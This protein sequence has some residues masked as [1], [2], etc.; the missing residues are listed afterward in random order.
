MSDITAIE[1]IDGWSVVRDPGTADIVVN[2]EEQEI[3][4][5]PGL[6]I[7]GVKFAEDGS[8][9]SVTVQLSSNTIDTIFAGEAVGFPRRMDIKEFRAFGFLQ[10]VNRQ[11]FHPLGLA[12]EVVVEDDGTE[13]LGGIWDFRDD[14][15]GIRYQEMDQGKAWRVSELQ[16]EKAAARQKALGY[17]IQ[18]IA[19]TP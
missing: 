17:V 19:D 13:R 9:G 10:E 12:L 16:H 6:E 18:G 7:L 5:P 4:C 8:G 3:T 11:F 14:P 1:E 15:E 2:F